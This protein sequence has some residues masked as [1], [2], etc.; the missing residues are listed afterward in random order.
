MFGVAMAAAALV[1]CG[2]TEMR[3]PPWHDGMSETPISTGSFAGR[4][5]GGAA[6]R[7]GAAGVGQSAGADAGRAGAAGTSSANQGGA[8][9]SGTFGG[10]AG[11]A[12]GGGS[13]GLGGGAG[14]ASPLQACA[15][16]ETP[17]LDGL[18]ATQM[19]HEPMISVAGDWNGDAKLDL[20]TVNLGGSIS[21]LLGHGDGTFASPVSYGV[22]PAA[23][24]WTTRWSTLAAR[25]LDGNGSLDLVIAPMHALWVSVL[26]GVG[27]GTFASPITYPLQSDSVEF[28]V[29]DFDGN[30]APDIAIAGSAG[31]ALLPNLGNG[32]FGAEVTVPI[33]PARLVSVA[34]GDLNHDGRLDLVTLNDTELAVLI[35]DGSGGFSKMQGFEGS[36]YESP[37]RIADMNADGHL[38]LLYPQV[39]GPRSW[40]ASTT[41][42][43]GRGDGTFATGASSSSIA[44]C[45]GTAD[46]ADVNGDGATD[47]LMSSPFAV[48]LGMKDGSLTPVKPSTASGGALLGTGDWN[49]DG[50]LDL[51]TAGREWLAIHL[52]N[53]DGS[54]GS[55]PVYETAFGSGS[56]ALADLDADGVLDIAAATSSPGARGWTASSLSVLRGSGSGTFPDRVDYPSALGSS[57]PAIVDLDG[58]GWLDLVTSVGDSIAARLSAGNASF[59]SELASTLETYVSARALGDL[60]GDGQPDIAAIIG[61]PSKLTLLFGSGDGTFV[62]NGAL[63]LPDLPVGVAVVDVNADQKQDLVLTL[64]E[65]AAVGVLLGN[66]DGSFV[67]ADRF[68]PTNHASHVTPADLNADG[69]VD[70]V[71]WGRRYTSNESFSVLLG[72]GNGSF[73]PPLDY[74]GDP[75][76]LAAVDF[77]GDGRQDLILIDE[78]GIAI[79]FGAGDGTFTCLT[80]YIGDS[81]SGLGMGD[82]NRDGRADIVTT[83][84]AG[85]NVFLNHAP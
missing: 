29:D 74:P 43:F 30:G 66:G 33:A 53:G 34:S 75:S 23:Q 73:A 61:W 72:N 8:A 31:L 42:F 50:K 57:D 40:R 17:I 81:M 36:I 18:P 78:A 7:A 51:A 10:A 32:R 63:Q 22:E 48:L 60:N 6:A 49:G 3:I 84:P 79:W 39:C 2:R 59:G 24:E 77:N 46:L 65:S 64:Y 44:S 35:G 80:R 20:A 52:G 69:H 15:R 27:D 19:E 1:A 62:A 68:Y 13:A 38:D 54:F 28:A 26:L 76:E 82:L 9:G 58:D 4:G 71:T 12:L 5:G 67:A 70:L 37:V 45:S 83:T 16:A 11:L 56:L 25:D 55:S 41:V 47:V 85:L 14:G 21:V